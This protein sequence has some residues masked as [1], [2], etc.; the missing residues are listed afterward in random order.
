MLLVGSF[1]LCRGKNDLSVYT[2]IKPNEKIVLLGY[3]DDYY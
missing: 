1:D 3:V 2:S